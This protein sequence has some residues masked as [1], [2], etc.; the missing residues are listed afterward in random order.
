MGDAAVG[1]S[2]KGEE[3]NIRFAELGIPVIRAVGMNSGV[4]WILGFFVWLSCLLVPC[5]RMLPHCI[6]KHKCPSGFEFP[7]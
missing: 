7:P 4:G 6:R 3:T 1:M 5:L 2:A